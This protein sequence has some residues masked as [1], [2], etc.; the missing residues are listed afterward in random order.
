MVKD[1]ISLNI[2]PNKSLILKPPN[3]EEKYYYAFLLGLF[4]GDGSIFKTK[5]NQFGFNLIGSFDIIS[6]ANKVLK[7]NAPLEQRFIKS[8]TY[9][10]RCGG[11]KKVY[12]L[13]Y[14]LYNSCDTHL[15]RKYLLF[16]ELESRL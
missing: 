10:I 12:N 16:K 1:L 5:N 6:W 3:I 13:L 11:T 9:Y 2:V 4:D 14:P 8:K 7:L 15:T